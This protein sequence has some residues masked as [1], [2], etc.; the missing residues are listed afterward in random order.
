MSY[1]NGENQCKKRVSGYPF[2]VFLGCPDDTRKMPERRRVWAGKLQE[3]GHREVRP[4]SSSE[5]CTKCGVHTGEC[6][7]GL[8]NMH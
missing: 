4:Q 8:G 5:Q 2:Y 1:V 6:D 7:A 3:S